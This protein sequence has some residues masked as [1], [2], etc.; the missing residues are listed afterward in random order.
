MVVVVEASLRNVV[1]IMEASLDDVVVIVE[2]SLD[3]VDVVANATRA[4]HSCP[5]GSLELTVESGLGR[6]LVGGGVGHY[7]EV[8]ATA[9]AV[10][11][12]IGESVCSFEYALEKS[13]KFPVA[14]G[15]KRHADVSM[16]GLV[17]GIS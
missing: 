11:C 3:D 9:I 5:F 16:Q 10:S 12:K 13:G 14:R 4:E 1:V 8:G 6:L 17:C 15:K 7:K 2:A